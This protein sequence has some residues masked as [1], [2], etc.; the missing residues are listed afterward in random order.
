MLSIAYLELLR[1]KCLLKYRSIKFISSLFLRSMAGKWGCPR[2]QEVSIFCIIGCTWYLSFQ[3]LSEK[4]RPTER[5][6]GGHAVLC[7][8]ERGEPS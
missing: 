6:S 8:T 1:Q 5:T 3:C 2:S 7:R 4:K